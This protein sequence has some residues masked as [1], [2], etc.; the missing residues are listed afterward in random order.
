MQFQHVTKYDQLVA[1]TM[2][3]M[4]ELLC[5]WNLMSSVTNMHKWLVSVNVKITLISE[6]SPPDM[7]K[8]PLVDRGTHQ[9]HTLLQVHIICFTFSTSS[10]AVPINPKSAVFIHI[11]SSDFCILV[12]LVLGNEEEVSSFTLPK[13]CQKT[14]GIVT[15]WTLSQ[16]TGHQRGAPALQPYYPV[17]SQLRI[18]IQSLAT[19]VAIK[20]SAYFRVAKYCYSLHPL[21][22]IY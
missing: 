8:L 19:K 2:C 14:A 4:N 17:S 1:G 5:C 3:S 10:N 11:V 12:P 22:F 15:C 6:S 16:L 7:R 13:Q 9:P 21:V 18:G 20:V